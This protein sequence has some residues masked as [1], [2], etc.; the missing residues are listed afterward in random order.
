MFFAQSIK[1][2]FFLVMILS[3]FS[4]G[5]I[6]NSKGQISGEELAY[7]SGQS[8]SS[9]CTQAIL[10]I[11]NLIAGGKLRKAEKELLALSEAKCNSRYEQAQLGRYLGHVYY[12]QGRLRES[13]AVFQKFIALPDLRQSQRQDTLYT[14]AQMCFIL[15]DYSGS[16]TALIQ[17]RKIAK[18]IDPQAEVLLARGYYKLGE[19]AE[20]L[21]IMQS[22]IADDK[23]RGHTTKSSWLGLLHDIELSTLTMKH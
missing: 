11:Q 15:E 1:T 5:L 19:K 18:Q 22:V 16:V 10:P 12:Q 2:A 7:E 3:L 4:C 23:S 17:R 14:I 8:I 6:S 13:I 21:T 20:S 9:K